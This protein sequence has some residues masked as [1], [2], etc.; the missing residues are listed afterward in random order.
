MMYDLINRG[1]VVIDY[2]KYLKNKAWMDDTKHNYFP[3]FVL[4]AL[5]LMLIMAA[6]ASAATTEYF[7]TTQ[8]HTGFTRQTVSL[9]NN[10]DLKAHIE[11]EASGTWSGLSDT[12]KIWEIT[13]FVRKHTLRAYADKCADWDSELT[14]AQLYAE[15]NEMSLNE[16]G[17]MCLGF[18]AV[19]MHVCDLYGYEA[20]AISAGDIGG[21]QWTHSTCLVRVL[22]DGHYKIIHADPYFGDMY[23]YSNSSPMSFFTMQDYID[24]DQFSQIYKKSIGYKYDMWT[25]SNSTYTG[26]G[27]GGYI[28]LD[29]VVET[30]DATGG[31]YKT[32][33]TNNWFIT[34]YCLGTYH[35]WGGVYSNP[36]EIWGAGSVYDAYDTSH[37][38][39]GIAYVEG[40]ET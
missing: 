33:R 7:P 40:R 34:P 28:S 15:F 29:Y 30:L 12:Q 10:D 35:I 23:T 14:T 31:T 13:K 24:A 11:A 32:W 1:Y 22:I 27:Y 16:H 21:T 4:I 17:Y 25:L 2:L 39:V 6:P 38:D 20:Y 9:A 37:N 36:Y 18:A 5:S 19:M 8:T 26:D 3:A